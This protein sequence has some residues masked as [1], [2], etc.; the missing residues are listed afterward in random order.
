MSAHQRLRSWKGKCIGGSL[1][2]QA[3]NN[4]HVQTLELFSARLLAGPGTEAVNRL[5]ARSLVRAAE[6]RWQD[7]GLERVVRWADGWGFCT[8]AA[9]GGRSCMRH[10]VTARGR[11]VQWLWLPLLKANRV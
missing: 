9:A 7:C 2:L 1:P 10:E 6:V 11:Q 4:P 3:Q 5:R 8:A